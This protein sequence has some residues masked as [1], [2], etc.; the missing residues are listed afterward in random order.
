[1]KVFKIITYG[2]TALVILTSCESSKKE[3]NPEAIARVGDHYLYRKDI[4]N[5]IP[6]NSTK[7]DSTL[8]VQS[9]IER[10]A[11]QKLLTEVSE[12]NLDDHQKKELEGLVNQY[13]IDLFTNAY[14]EQMV[15][16]S[17]DTLVTKEEMQQYYN[18]HKTNFRT[19]IKLVKLRYIQV[20][21]EHQKFKEIK[22]KFFNPKKSD[23]E[24]WDTY[25]VQLNSAALNDSVWVDLNQI[26]QRVPFINPENVEQY[27]QPGKVHEHQVDNSIYFI[28]VN[29]VL[30][31]NEIS[32]F[33][34]I[35]P[36]IKQVIINKRKLEF[37]KQIEKEI[38]LDAY[39]NKK[40]EIYKK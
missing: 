28:K 13:K 9:Y 24:F 19:N 18:E 10:W 25:Q 12:I 23:Y 35:Q 17:I 37:V 33:E 5:L 2:I 6:E 4:E 38:I 16:K 30:K 39:K 11:T 34:Y 26:Y 8:I 27:I 1:M 20:P 14:I 3:L 7:E 15:R 21:E 40:Y 22:E 32:P 36:T 31:E 29:E